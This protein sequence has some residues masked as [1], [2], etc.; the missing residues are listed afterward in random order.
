MLTQGVCAAMGS[1]AA[2]DGGSRGQRQRLAEEDR[3]L[4]GHRR[5]RRRRSEEDRTI[6]VASLGSDTAVKAE[7]EKCILIH[8]ALIHLPHSQVTPSCKHIIIMHPMQ[9]KKNTLPHSQLYAHAHTHGCKQITHAQYTA[10]PIRSYSQ[11]TYKK[12]NEDIHINIT[13]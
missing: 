7:Q 1:F 10:Q 4:L 8:H 3:L 12:E 9:A 13:Q 2:I 5:A 11:H 6:T